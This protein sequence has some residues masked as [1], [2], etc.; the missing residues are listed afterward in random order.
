MRFDAYTATTTEANPY[1]LADL[2]GPGLQQK[3]GRGFHQFANRLALLDDGHEVGS[4]QWGGAHGE[5]TMIEV[6]GE[7]TPA[8][9]S[10][11][12]SRFR[13]GVTR[14]DSCADFDAPGA[15][16]CLLEPLLAVKKKH[17]LKGRKEGDW[18]DFPEEG[19]TQYV[20][21]SKSVTQVRLYEKGKQPEYRH[22]GRSDWVRA[23]TQVRPGTREAKEAYSK[24]SP[25]DTWG[26]SAWT[27]EYAALVLADHVDPHPAGT[28]WRKTDLDQRLMFA[29]RQYGPTFL[30]LFELLG[31][32][33][34]VGLT[35]NEQIKEL[36]RGGK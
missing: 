31:S 2:F 28:T 14:V 12:R 13:H 35:I 19:R 17:R 18:E 10:A 20:G 26:A 30:E 15:F 8:V 4:V 11:L 32:W 3:Q 25:L 21:S 23:E 6:K 5:R 1:Q 27:A 34:C 24:I 29:C 33:E 36:Q 22:L 9:A 7:R 16:S